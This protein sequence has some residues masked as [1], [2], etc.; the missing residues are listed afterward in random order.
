MIPDFSIFLIQLTLFFKLA[1][2]TFDKFE[3]YVHLLPLGKKRTKQFRESRS[4]IIP[5]M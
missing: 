5:M 2:L 4:S 1:L 3:F